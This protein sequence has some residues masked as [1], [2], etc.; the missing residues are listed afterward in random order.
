MLTTTNLPFSAK[1]SFI[2][3]AIIASSFIFYVGQDIIIPLLLSVFFAII[4][5][6][7]VI[8][9]KRRFFVPRIIGAIIAVI[10][11]IVVIVGIFAYISFQVSDM[12]NDINKIQNNLNIHL[13]N[14]QGFIREH[15][16]M[17]MGEQKKLINQAAKDSLE[18]GK[19]LIGVTITTFSNTILNLILIPI[20][21]FL[22]LIYSNHFKIFFIK[23]IDKA[24]HTTLEDILNQ[25][26]STVKNYIFGLIV[27]MIFVSILT[28]VG[29]M[30]IGI[31][32]AIV[33]GIITGILNLIPYI[34]ILFAGIL[35]ILASLTGSSDLSIIIGVIV[36]NAIVQLID[37]NILVPLVVSSKVKI[38]A[39]A[40]IV[41]VL[42]GGAIAG[43]AGMFLAIPIIAIFKVIFDRIDDLEPWGY[44]IGDDLPKTQQWKYLKVPKY[45]YDNFTDTST[46]DKELNITI[47]STSEIN[48]ENI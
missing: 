36:V 48:S 9:L 11:F 8:F 29:L 45:D 5:Q 42:I 23:L 39:I 30:F 33:L 47:T 21:T 46:I 41:G 14:A 20:Y 19:E 28:A 26:K 25:I 38:N 13:N 2:L 17:S 24:H 43:I 32:Y 40:T 10:I 35:T 34:G 18:K 12:V 27:E 31:K 37:N 16:H 4:L 44:L 6:P 7:I 1:L 3:I 22:I 15:L